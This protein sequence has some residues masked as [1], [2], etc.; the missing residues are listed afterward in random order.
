MK[1]M[2]TVCD[3]YM[4]EED[5]VCPKCQHTDK[6]VI[7]PG[8]Y[9]TDF[10]P[11]LRSACAAEK[12]LAGVRDSTELALEIEKLVEKT[13]LIA[14]T[15]AG[16]RETLA[17]LTDAEIRISSLTHTSLRRESLAAVCS[18]LKTLKGKAEVAIQ[19][20][21]KGFFMGRIDE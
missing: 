3:K 21:E 1:R 16:L 11:F 15:Q 20:I 17:S 9:I 4:H 18:R 10:K 14:A 7:K 8:P 6:R 12:K 19:L 13:T 5:T 2:C